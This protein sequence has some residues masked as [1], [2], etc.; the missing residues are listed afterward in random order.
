M[1]KL[2]RKLKSFMNDEQ[3]MEF[4]EVAGIIIGAI[5]LVGAIFVLMNNFGNAVKS[6][7]ISIPTDA[8]FTFSVQP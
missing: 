8:G 5:A 6:V 3:G 2:I 4:I 7:P 1:K